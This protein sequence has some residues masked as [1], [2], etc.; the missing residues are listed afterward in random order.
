[1]FFF[2]ELLCRIS[3]AISPQKQVSDLGHLYAFV[4][5]NY[6]ARSHVWFADRYRLEHVQDIEAPA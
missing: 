2:Q 1:M 5:C 6:T 4:L 3:A